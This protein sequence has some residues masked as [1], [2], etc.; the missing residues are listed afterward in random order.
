MDVLLWVLQL[1]LALLF[2]T[3]GLTKLTAQRER[4]L[5]SMAWVSD[6]PQG[7]VRS[8]GAIEIT[9]AISL[10]VPASL[11]YV[12]SLTPIAAAGLAAHMFF[13]VALHVRRREP[14]GVIV[15]LTLAALSTFIA[16]GRFGPYAF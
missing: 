13:A 7:A 8:I 1:T 3:A 4:L 2:F 6:F 11:D 12:P 16:W 5:Q 9:A 15:A 10:V 14:T